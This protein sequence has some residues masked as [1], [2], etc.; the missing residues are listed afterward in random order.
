MTESVEELKSGREKLLELEAEGKYLF[1]GSENPNLDHLEPRQG[2]N[3]RDGIQEPDGEPAVFTSNR[4]DYAILMALVNK[5]NCPKGY[6]SSAGTEDDEKGEIVLKLKATK[7]S[8]EQLTEDSS[9][10]VY[11]FDKN[12]FVP[13][14]DRRVEFVSKVP[15]TSVNKIEVFKWDLPPYVEVMEK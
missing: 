15:V 10:Y 13:R 6:A 7:E 5:H 3:F 14:E 4:A 11:I 1:H 12:L 9:G 8:I 2:Y